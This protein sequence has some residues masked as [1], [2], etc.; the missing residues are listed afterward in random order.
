MF[1]NSQAF[2]QKKFWPEDPNEDYFFMTQM[3]DLASIAMNL[4]V[5]DSLFDENIRKAA[6]DLY[7]F[8]KYR[9]VVYERNLDIPEL[10]DHHGLCIYA[11]VADAGDFSQ[12]YSNR[13]T[14]GE[15]T[16]WDRV[17]QKIGNP[18]SDGG[19]K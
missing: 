10:A 7:G 13:L 14:L 6:V 5:S 8:I 11:P 19:N 16:L 3:R 15:A 4:A 18:A 17:V 12:H 9:L 2:S 1:H